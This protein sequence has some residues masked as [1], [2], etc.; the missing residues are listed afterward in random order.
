MKPIKAVVA[1]SLLGSL[2]AYALL[3]PD[4]A[5]HSSEVTTFK[6]TKYP[7]DQYGRGIKHFINEMSECAAYLAI[8][9]QAAS[10]DEPEDARRHHSNTRLALLM[11]NRYSDEDHINSLFKS[12][13]HRQMT[14]IEHDYSKISELD[15]F[16]SQLCSKSLKEPNVRLQYW[17]DFNKL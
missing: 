1:L 6:G 2:N 5:H 14:I 4:G 17:I 3:A 9:A 12:A 15:D 11:G 7:V 8:S 10:E 13:F 16:Y